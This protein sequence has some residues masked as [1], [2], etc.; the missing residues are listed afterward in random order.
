MTDEWQ[1]GV[2]FTHTLTLELDD[3][4][5]SLVG[6]AR[7]G[8]AARGIPVLHQPAHIT[9]ACVDSMTGVDA[10]LVGSRWPRSVTLA[11]AC[12]L[13]NSDGVASLCLHGAGGP[14][15]APGPLLGEH[16]RLHERLA[17]AGVTTFTYYGPEHWHPHV[18][19]GYRIPAHRVGAAVDLLGAW[20]PARVGV[21]AVTVWEVGSGRTHTLVEL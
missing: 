6:R 16:R 9:L 7:D 3:A 1:S 11:S 19:V 17:R 15:L 4:A 10:A 13:P 18:T 20:A 21:R 5:Q 8:L 12:P 2:V 14:D